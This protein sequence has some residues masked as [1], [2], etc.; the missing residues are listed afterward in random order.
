MQP[1]FISTIP[2][3]LAYGS[4]ICFLFDWTFLMNAPKFWNSFLYKMR[5]KS[6]Q[7]YCLM[8]RK[9][10]LFL[11]STPHWNKS[12][13]LRCQNILWDCLST[14]YD[15]VCFRHHTT[16]PNRSSTPFPRLNLNNI[17]KKADTSFL[18]SVFFS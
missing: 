1:Y 5:R 12:R 16:I 8:N 2:W 6:Y 3:F 11:T 10:G 4:L 15:L 7:H 13:A 18:L 9:L 17:F 14:C